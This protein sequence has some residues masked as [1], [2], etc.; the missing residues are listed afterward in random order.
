ME[1]TPLPASVRAVLIAVAGVL[2]LVGA[3]GLATGAADNTDDLAT[4]GGSTTTTF[5]STNSTLGR[6]S[7]VTTTTLPGATGTTAKAPTATTAKPGSAT[8]TTTVAA[9]DTN[10]CASPPD[11]S[12]NPGAIVAPAVG[13]YSFVSCDDGSMVDTEKIREGSNG[14]GKLRRL[15]SHDQQGVQLT[16][17]VAYG[18]EGVLQEVLNVS[19]FGRQATCD[20]NPDILEYPANLSV[21]ATWS[22]KSQCTTSFGPFK[23]EGTGKVVGRKT[24]SIGGTTVNTWVVQTQIKLQTPQGNQE[25][26]E[27]DYF[28]PSRG[29]DLYRKTVASDGQGGKVT[30][31]R[32]LASL[33]PG[34]L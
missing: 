23:V 25:A 10:A 2:V 24:V 8:G 6:G 1:P 27:L 26:D 11:S 19:A 13:T 5:S 30:V 31:V 20:W 34:P 7:D 32:R 4:A 33:T 15:V 3:G 9:V 17:T 22:V 12:T 18:P 14:G 16:E 28:D 21:G 29:I